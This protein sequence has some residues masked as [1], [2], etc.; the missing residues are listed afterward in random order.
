MSQSR[1]SWSGGGGVESGL[2]EKG[3]HFRCH[4][5]DQLLGGGPRAPHLHQPST[6][7]LDTVHH[8]VSLCKGALAIQSAKVCKAS[9]FHPLGPGPGTRCPR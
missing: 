9:A 6:A 1:H 3:G 2:R 7:H 8:G 4:S 5:S